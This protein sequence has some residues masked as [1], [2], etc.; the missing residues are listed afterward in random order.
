MICVLTGGTG[1]SKMV[2][3]LGRVVGQSNLTAI[4]NTADDDDFYGLR[5]CPDLDICTYTLA[6][7]VHGRG[8][9]YGGDTFRCLEGLATYGQP[10]WFGIG[11]RDLATHLHRTIMLSRGST[12]AEVTDDICA[13][14]GVEVTLLPMSNDAVRTRIR[15]AE[16]DRSFEEYLVQHGAR[17]DILEITI[18]G[19]VHAQPTPGVL[20]A[21]AA[22]ETIVIAPSS[23]VV[24]IGTILAVPGV[25]DAL[26]MRRDRVV[27]VSPIVGLSPVEGPGHKFLA[28]I[29]ETDCRAATLA[30]M[31]A[32]VCSTF[33][34]DTTDIEQVTEIA[35]QD[36][37]AVACDILMPDPSSRVALAEE[38]LKAMA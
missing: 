21:I 34:I 35:A 32:D 31:Y 33:L 17:E 11:D 22:A 16:G 7:V 18:D 12:L 27:G 37:R 6:G 19:A 26:A 10:S 23:P 1:G 5:V 30:R 9:G 29:G 20:A 24:S 36:V 15:T 4:V 8:W 25:R 13:R 28:A 3:G 38:A 2:D 14:L